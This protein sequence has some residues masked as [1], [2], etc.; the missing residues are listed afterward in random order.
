LSRLADLAPRV[1]L[2]ALAWLLNLSHSPYIPVIP[3]IS[4]QVRS[5]ISPSSDRAA[6]QLAVQIVCVA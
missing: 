1:P 4:V 6:G 3:T 2:L 5:A